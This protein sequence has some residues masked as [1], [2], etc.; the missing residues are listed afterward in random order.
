MPKT[1][2]TTK[3]RIRDLDE[4]VRAFSECILS[5]PETLF[6]AKLDEH[7]SPREVT[8]HLIG[9]NRLTREG[10]EQ[11][12]MGERPSYFIDP[13]DDFSKVNA[14]SI[15]RYSSTNAGELVSELRA[16]MRELTQYLTSLDSTEWGVD[17]G[18]R[19]RGEPV[20]IINT[21][22]ALIGDYNTHRQQIHRW[23]R[24]RT[25]GTTLQNG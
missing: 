18:I 11:M 6:L 8:A 12:I 2:L 5:L 13:G 7:W 19:Y 21:L 17:R 1:S 9:W 25:E 16:S 3:H 4:C 23:A 14:R 15:R 22:D 20:T 24:T 10:A